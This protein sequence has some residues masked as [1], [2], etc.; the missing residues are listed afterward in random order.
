MADCEALPRGPGVEKDKFRK[1]VKTG[2]GG[3][4]PATGMLR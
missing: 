4:I 3:R 2:R 1:G